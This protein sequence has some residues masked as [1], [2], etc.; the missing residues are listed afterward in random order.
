MLEALGLTADEESLWQVLLDRPPS[1]IGEVC[2]A[3]GLGSR[4]VSLAIANLERKGLVIR[5]SGRPAR[6]TV[7]AP[8]IALEE[9][10]RAKEKK[11]HQVRLLT[12]QVMHRYRSGRRAAAPEDVIEVVVG[13]D[14]I[15]QRCR[16]INRAASAEVC[17][18][19]R[20]PFLGAAD[21]SQVEPVADGMS[22]RTVIDTSVLEL[23][24]RIAVM[25]ELIR[26]GEQVRVGKVPVKVL[27]GD[28]HVGMIALEYPD[29]TDAV[30][31][32][33]SSSLLVAL[34][35]L[36]ESIW[37]I[38]IP[39]GAAPTTNGA[40]HRQLLTFLA[41]GMT[42]QAIARQLGWHLSTVQRKVRRLMAE[43]GVRTRF[44]AGLQAGRRGWL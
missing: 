3:I 34:R 17:N 24:G 36:F 8:D 32:V 12:E 2:D 21:P 4:A 18:L 26:Q 29:T 1:T 39:I 31:V 7:T 35:T 38:A 22:G 40:V 25:E 19:S 27:L 5:L 9:L 14:A 20:P 23:P 33:H 44:Q 6:Y 30:L 28:D 16:Q 41:A 37:A 15:L 43:L 10:V 13:A 11:L 42:D